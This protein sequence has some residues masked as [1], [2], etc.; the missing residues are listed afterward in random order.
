VLY[1]NSCGFC[2]WWV[3]YW[4][5]TLSKRGFEIAPL[6]TDWVAKQFSL[7]HDTLVN[8]LRLLLSDGK[9][10]AGADVYGCVLKQI[11]WAYLLYVFAIL[12]G[13]RAAFDWG[14]RT[15]ARNRYRVSRACRLSAQSK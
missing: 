5:D 14:Y 3:P 9:T 15:F 8:D 12:P 2:R 13:T 1:D 10:L 4:K 7:P 6:Q 11:W